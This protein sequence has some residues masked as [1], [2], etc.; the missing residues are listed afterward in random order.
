MADADEIEHVPVKRLSKPLSTDEI[1]NKLGGADKTKGSCCSLGLAFVGNENGL[2]VTD[3]RGGKSQS[4]FAS[5]LAVKDIAN[6]ANVD[7]QIVKSFNEIETAAQL[8]RGIEKNK[9]YFL[10]VGKHVS[11]VRHDEKLGLQY[12]ELQSAKENGFKKLDFAALKNRFGA[13]KQ[14][15]QYKQKIE[16]DVILIKNESLKNNKEFENILGYLNTASEKQLKGVGGGI[17]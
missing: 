11:I 3:Y 10:C 5:R 14:H 9:N 1:I 17:K 12:L 15:T 16:L 6:L 4:L 2:D 7:A 13:K 8:L